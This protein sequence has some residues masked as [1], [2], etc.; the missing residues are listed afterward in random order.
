[1]FLNLGV[2]VGQKCKVKSI[3]TNATYVKHI[4]II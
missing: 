3:V 1:M 2:N 4:L